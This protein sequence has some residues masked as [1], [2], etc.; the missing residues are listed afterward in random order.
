MKLSNLFLHDHFFIFNFQSELSGIKLA[1]NILSVRPGL[2]R[3]VSTCLIRL[4]SGL[5][6]PFHHHNHYSNF[7]ILILLAEFYVLTVRSSI[8]GP[9]L[10]HTIKK[11]LLK[12]QIISECLF[13]FL[14][15]PK[16]HRKIW[17]KC[18]NHKI[19][20]L[21]NVFNTLNSPYNHRIIRKCLPIL[22]WFDHF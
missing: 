10:V 6:C 19:T 16:K 1:W 11:Y 18:S 14:N 8:C 7:K 17:Q 5:T 15:F 12:G 4:K 13:D 21:Y 2:I 22:C 9:F 3:Q 20:A